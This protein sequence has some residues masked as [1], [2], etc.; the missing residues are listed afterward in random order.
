MVVVIYPIANLAAMG[1]ELDLRNAARTLRD[2]RFVTLILVLGWLAGPA[3]AYLI[4]RTIPLAE[5]H[6]AGLLLISL[7]PT[8][9]FFPLMVI[10]VVRLEPM[11]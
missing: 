7:A 6:A 3:L 1:L 4:T 2:P 9:P 8:A 5:G 11:T 10:R